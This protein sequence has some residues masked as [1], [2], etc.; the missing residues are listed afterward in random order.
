MGIEP[1]SPAAGAGLRE[2]DI[3]VAFKGETVAS[4]DQLQRKL[5]AAE[6][7]VKS[8]V[9]VLRQTEKLDRVITPAE[10]LGNVARN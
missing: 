10:W 2:G 3:L 1:H 4:I 9:T 8:L 6:I 7:G 5:V